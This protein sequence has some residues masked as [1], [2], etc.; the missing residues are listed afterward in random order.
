VKDGTFTL[1]GKRVLKR[2]PASIEYIVVDVTESPI[3]RPAQNQKEY[4][5]IVASDHGEYHC[6]Q[7][8]NNAEK[9]YYV[10]HNKLLIVLLCTI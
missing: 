3:N 10:F 7:E 1:P 4:C 6:H 2:K 5:A 8:G 9:F